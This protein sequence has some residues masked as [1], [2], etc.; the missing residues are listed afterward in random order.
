MLLKG[1][2]HRARLGLMPH[3]AEHALQLPP[4]LRAKTVFLACLAKVRL[5]LLAQPPDPRSSVRFRSFTK[6]AITKAVE[7]RALRPRIHAM[8]KCFHFGKRRVYNRRR[9]EVTKNPS[10]P[11]KRFHKVERH[12]PSRIEGR[13]RTIKLTANPGANEPHLA[14]GLE[15]VSQEHTAVDLRTIGRECSALPDLKRRART[16]K[17]TANLGAQEPYFAAG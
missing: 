16:I 10:I 11:H 3:L 9:L 2:P 15:A 13:A 17:L 8:S 4:G 6:R 1:N 14:A 7:C 12:A 5:G